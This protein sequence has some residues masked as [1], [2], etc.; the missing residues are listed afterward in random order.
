MTGEVKWGNDAPPLTFH[1]FPILP[2]HELSDEF[3]KV[4]GSNV[5]PCTLYMN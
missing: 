5:P 1:L 4:K 3:M 2:M